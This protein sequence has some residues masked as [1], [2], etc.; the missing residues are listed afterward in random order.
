MSINYIIATYPAPSQSR[1]SDQYPEVMLNFHLDELT[2][3]F[4]V[5]KRRDIECLIKYVTIVCPEPAKDPFKN[6]Y[7][8][9][10]W[11][12]RFQQ[13]YHNVTLQYVDYV[14]YNIDFP[15]DHWIQG[16]QACPDADYHLLIEDGYCV[17]RENP[18]FDLDLLD[19]YKEKFPNNIGYLA[20]WVPTYLHGLPRHAAISNGLVSKETFEKLGNPLRKFYNI[21]GIN[22][23]QVRFSNLFALNEIPMADFS[24]R[25]RIYFWETRS[26]WIMDFSTPNTPDRFIFVPIQKYL[27]MTR[28]KVIR[29]HE[30]ELTQAQIAK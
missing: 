22:L 25:Y 14:G 29:K 17:E 10:K 15:C 21:R 5:K 19:L 24:D 11:K 3:L 28:P 18:R 13:D 12:T 30:W 23:P 26:K 9:K 7:Q 8:D 27:F 2:R 16:Y 20:T 1:P 4:R 6:Y